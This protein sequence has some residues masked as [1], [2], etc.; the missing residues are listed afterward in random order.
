MAPG[1]ESPLVHCKVVFGCVESN[2]TLEIACNALVILKLER[3]FALHFAAPSLSVVP[4]SKR[5]IDAS[6]LGSFF[7]WVCIVT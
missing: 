7:S 5:K 4:L 6:L 2:K 3:K 1:Y